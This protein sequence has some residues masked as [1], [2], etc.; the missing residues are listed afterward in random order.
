MLHAG[1]YKDYRCNYLASYGGG[2]RLANERHRH[3]SALERRWLLL[4]GMREGGS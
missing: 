4:L 2:H 1:E 3:D